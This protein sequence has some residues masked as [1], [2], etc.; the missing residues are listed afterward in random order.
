V[1]AARFVPAHVNETSA[2]VDNIGGLLSV[3]GVGLAILTINFAPEPGR[4]T[5]VLSCGC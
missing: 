3:A 5:L 2:A 4:A 1:L